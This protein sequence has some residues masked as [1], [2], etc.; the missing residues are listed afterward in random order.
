MNTVKI[1][2]VYDLLDLNIKAGIPTLLVGDSGIGKTSIIRQYAEDHGLEL[3]TLVGSYRVAG[4][5]QMPMPVKEKGK[6]EIQ[7]LDTGLLPEPGSNTLLFLDEWNNSPPEI[8][9][10]FL[11]ILAEG[12]MGNRIVDCPI[13]MAANPNNQSVGYKQLPPI[14]KRVC[15]VEVVAD[16]DYF[17]ENLTE[18]LNIHPLVAG[19]LFHNKVAISSSEQGYYNCPRQWVK[20]SN[21]IRLDPE[22]KQVTRASIYG[23]LGNEAVPFFNHLEVSAKFSAP[24]VYYNGGKGILP[25]N[26]LEAVALGTHLILCA[27]NTENVRAGLDVLHSASEQN[28]SVNFQEVLPPLLSLLQQLN[29]E[30][31]IQLARESDLFSD[32]VKSEISKLKEFYSELRQQDRD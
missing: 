15:E 18:K 9:A 3:W 14:R 23:L 30:T 28:D 25:A 32:A 17:L 1:G 10:N 22:L 19:Y 21:C 24:D 5:L 27:N 26:Q 29:K 11:E 6:T 2:E 8:Q 12:K 16:C 31:Y 4:D 20:V 13:V 7:W